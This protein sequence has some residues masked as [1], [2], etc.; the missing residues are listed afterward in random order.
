MTRDLPGIL[1]TGFQGRPASVS[2]RSNAFGA[3]T[4]EFP[5][6]EISRD[7]K[8]WLACLI[9]T[10]SEFI[11][12]GGYALAH[13][14]C[15]RFTGDIDVL[16]R[17]TEE[18]ARRVLEALRQFGFGGLEIGVADL[19]TPGRVV[20][21]GFPPQ[22]IDLLTRIDGLDWTE[23]SSDPS[24]DRSLGIEIPYISRAALIAN[25]RASGRLKDL[26]DVE[27]LEGRSGRRD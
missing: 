9:A 8:E 25:K 20:Q 15:P 24:I 11:V 6:M 3:S 16:V 10:K 5:S 17:P 4:T 13:H 27:A 14:G 19:S 1:P 22:R 21:L 23:A 26:A 12:V 2:R 18:N 7:F